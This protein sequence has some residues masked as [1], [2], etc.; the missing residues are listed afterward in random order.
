MPHYLRWSGFTP[1]R[2]P[3]TEPGTESKMSNLDRYCKILRWAAKRYTRDGLLIVQVG[4][5]Q[6]VYHLIE[7]AAWN[8][9]G[10]Y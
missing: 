8:R 9:Y 5:G 1:Q 6:S 2:F 10:K 3:G 4:R 7:L